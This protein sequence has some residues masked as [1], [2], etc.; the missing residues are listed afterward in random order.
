MGVCEWD[1]LFQEAGTHHI[2][3]KLNDHSTMIGLSQEIST[4]ID[5]KLITTIISCAVKNLQGTIGECTWKISLSPLRSHQTRNTE[6][7]NADI[8][9]V[10][11]WVVI[12]FRLCIFVNSAQL[13]ASTI[14]ARAWER[15]RWAPPLASAAKSKNQYSK[16]QE[17]MIKSKHCSPS[18]INPILSGQLQNDL[19]EI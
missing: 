4:G 16:F 5:S 18:D 2:L 1:R 9:A 7:I 6:E 17:K 12:W 13:F 15:S 11:T 19:V 8:R 14:P 10:N 3:E